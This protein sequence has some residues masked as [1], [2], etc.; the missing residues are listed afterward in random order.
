MTWPVTCLLWS[1]SPIWKQF[2]FGTHGECY[3]LSSASALT[4]LKLSIFF[5][6]GIDYMT[7][8]LRSLCGELFKGMQG[9]TGWLKTICQLLF[10]GM[11]LK[12]NIN[13]SWFQ[14]LI[15]LAHVTSLC[16]ATM[17]NQAHILCLKVGYGRNLVST[18]R[19]VFYST[20]IRYGL[21]SQIEIWFEYNLF[22]IP[23]SM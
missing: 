21:Q 17:I 6:Q 4:L 20:R 2:M 22:H 9:C 18:Q 3:Q 19:E 13:S 23:D 12:S 7:A 16:D 11:P 1:N 14:N 8:M 10:S 15:H 5:L